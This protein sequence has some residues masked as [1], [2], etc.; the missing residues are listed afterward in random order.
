[1][2]DYYDYEKKILKV[3]NEKSNIETQVIEIPDEWKHLNLIS[4]CPLIFFGDLVNEVQ[5]Y[6]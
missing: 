3:Y 2:I 4:G 5:V 1:M 6:V